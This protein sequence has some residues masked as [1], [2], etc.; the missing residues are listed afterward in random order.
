MVVQA[1]SNIRSA[2]ASSSVEIVPTLFLHSPQRILLNAFLLS[3]SSLPPFISPSIAASYSSNFII[4]ESW[5][6][7][8]FRYFFT[9]SSSTFLASKGKCKK[10]KK[11]NFALQQ[12]LKDSENFALKILSSSSSSPNYFKSLFVELGHNPKFLARARRAGSTLC[13][14]WNFMLQCRKRPMQSVV[15]AWQNSWNFAGWCG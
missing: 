14:W 7:T 12:L 1:I 8:D 11:C 4:S 6:N 13:N 2:A 5:I 15:V 3:P 10:K 9:A